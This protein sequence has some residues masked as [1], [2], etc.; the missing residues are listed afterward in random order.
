MRFYLGVSVWGSVRYLV[1]GASLF[2]KPLIARFFLCYPYLAWS[3]QTLMRVLNQLRMCGQRVY[4]GLDSGGFVGQVKLNRNRHFNF[5]GYKGF[6]KEFGGLFEICL[7]WDY[8]DEKECWRAFQSLIAN[9]L[10]VTPVWKLGE[11]PALL[12]VYAKETPTGWVAIGGFGLLGRHNAKMSKLF[13]TLRMMVMRI[14]DECPQ[15]S[16]HALGCG[17][18]LTLLRI[19]VPDSADSTTPLQSQ[20]YG[21]LVHIKDGKVARTWYRNLTQTDL[22][23]GVSLAKFRMDS[24]LRSVVHAWCALKVTELIN[25]SPTLP[26]DDR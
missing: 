5:E 2:G 21:L 4:F 19:W 10:K 17:L 13:E 25:L 1:A 14:K 6:L 8:G 7:S 22:P 12:R 3:E 11:D 20:R 9:G 18:N 16:F 23:E 15:V 24:K 26:V